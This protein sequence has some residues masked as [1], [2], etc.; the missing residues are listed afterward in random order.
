MGLLALL[1][2]TAAA[3][4]TITLTGVITQSPADAQVTAVNNFTLNSV[5]DN[6]LYRVVLSLTGPVG[7]TGNYTL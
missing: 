1:A 2:G 4:A 3:A 5:A 7:G 6:D